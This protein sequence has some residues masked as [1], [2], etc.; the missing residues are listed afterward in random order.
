MSGEGECPVTVSSSSS[1]SRSELTL[2][3]ASKQRGCVIHHCALNRV[4][5]AAFSAQSTVTT[6][7][8]ASC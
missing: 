8:T 7:S 6:A 1:S 3:V 2:A 4:R 5:A